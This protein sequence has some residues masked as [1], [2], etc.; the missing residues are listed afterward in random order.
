VKPFK[1]TPCL[2]GKKGILPV[3]HRK[4]QVGKGKRRERTASTPPVWPSNEDH[5][6]P[7]S[8]IPNRGKSGERGLGS[9][10]PGGQKRKHADKGGSTFRPKGSVSSVQPSGG[11]GGKQK[12][13]TNEVQK[14]LHK[15]KTK[16]SA[17]DE[18]KKIGGKERRRGLELRE[19]GPDSPPPASY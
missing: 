12:A 14:T 18:T 15:M 11:W 5:D 4:D 1:A 10:R 19:N 8:R 2:G 17:T 16:G 6:R 7:V 3:G 9:E 13:F